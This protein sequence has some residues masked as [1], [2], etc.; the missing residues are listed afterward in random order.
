M[1]SKPSKRNS[2]IDWLNPIRVMFW[3]SPDRFHILYVFGIGIYLQFLR[4]S[5]PDGEFHN[6]PWAGLAI[7]NGTY[8]EEVLKPRIKRYVEQFVWIPAWRFH[9][10][11]LD[12]HVGPVTELI[13][14]GPPINRPKKLRTI[15][16][17]TRTLKISSP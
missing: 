1:H 5:C 13:L 16:S 15:G 6:H 4:Q 7:T 12:A 11:E 14:H 2:E 3:S 10:I 9:R 17:W 8:R